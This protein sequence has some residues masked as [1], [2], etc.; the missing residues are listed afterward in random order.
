MR[1]AT[2]R[3]EQMV[4][5]PPWRALCD[6]NGTFSAALPVPPE[7]LRSPMT[8][9][10]TVHAVTVPGLERMPAQHPQPGPRRSRGHGSAVAGHDSTEAGIPAAWG[11]CPALMRMKMCLRSGRARAVN[12]T[13]YAIFGAHLIKR[14]TGFSGAA[15]GDILDAPVLVPGDRMRQHHSAATVVQALNRVRSPGSG[16]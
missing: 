11:E 15:S 16:V 2:K 12:S 4:R 10:P 7:N 5:F 6:L 8:K 3:R 14:R 1:C 9:L 13:R